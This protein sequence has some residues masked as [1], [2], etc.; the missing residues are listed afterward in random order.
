[1]KDGYK[2]ILVSITKEIEVNN[3]ENGCC[4]LRSCMFSEN[5][6]KTFGAP[7]A[8]M[9]YLA[10]AWGL[11]KADCFQAY[12]NRLEYSRMENDNGDEPSAA[13]MKKFKASKIDL[14]AAD[15]SIALE[16]VQSYEPDAEEIAADFQV[17]EY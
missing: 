12:E 14:W 8:A 13:E 4:G 15:Y 11:D 17:A 16:Y 2:V 3:Y 9:E 10:S 6:N 1:M 5:I 7:A